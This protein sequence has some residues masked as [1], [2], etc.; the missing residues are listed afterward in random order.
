MIS[1]RTLAMIGIFMAIGVGGIAITQ[2]LTES[3]LW[4]VVGGLI[5]VAACFYG[6][7]I[8]SKKVK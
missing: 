7:K 5:T 3:T 1:T 2:R 8:V 4:G 6:V